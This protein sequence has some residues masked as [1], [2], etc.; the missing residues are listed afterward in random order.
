M[1][2]PLRD[3]N[4]NKINSASRYALV[5][6]LLLMSCYAWGEKHDKAPRQGRAI[7]KDRPAQTVA[8]PAGEAEY[9]GTLDLNSGSFLVTTT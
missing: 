5:P 3:G 7:D 4:P 8:L 6:M 2:S 1:V 9:V